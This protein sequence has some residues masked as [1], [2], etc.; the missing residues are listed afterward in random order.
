MV[1][2]FDVGENLLKKKCPICNKKFKIG[3][4]II[5]CPIQASKKGWTN[6]VAL[7]IHTKCYWITKDDE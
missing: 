2:E 4:K 5:L 1:R 3:E 7:P 6:A